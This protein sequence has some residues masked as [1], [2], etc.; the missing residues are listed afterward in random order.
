[1]PATTAVTTAYLHL[2]QQVLTGALYEDPPAATPF[3]PSNQ[4]PPGFRLA[5]RVEGADWPAHAHT[6]I[7]LKRLDNVQRCVEGVL[8]DDVPGD[9][10]ETGVWR[11]G[12]CIFLRALLTAYGDTERSV[13]VADSFQGLPRGGDHPADAI[14]PYFEAE[15]TLAVPEEEVRRNF[16]R[17]GLLDERVRFLPGWFA[18]TLPSAPIERLAVLRLDGDRYDSTMDALVHLYP[19]LSPGGFCIIDDYGLDA[20]QTAV[21]EYRAKEGIAEPIVKVDRFGAYWRRAA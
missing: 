8:D 2:L 19:R 15:G 13:W 7:G 4:P 1:M 3:R 21:A 12:T 9:F 11:G 10:I 17:Y 20:C 18:D 16:A 14:I 5:D 6:M